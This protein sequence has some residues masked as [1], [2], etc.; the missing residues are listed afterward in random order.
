MVPYDPAP[1]SLT[2]NPPAF[3]PPPLYANYVGGHYHDYDFSFT[4]PSPAHYTDY[5]PTPPLEL[6]DPILASANRAASPFPYPR[7]HPS[8]LSQPH[9]PSPHTSTSFSQHYHPHSHSRSPHPSV[10]PQYAYHPLSRPTSA[11]STPSRDSSPPPLIHQFSPLGLPSEQKEQLPPRK[12]SAGDLL[13]WHHLARH[14]EIPGVEDDERARG[15]NN[16][17]AVIA[18]GKVSLSFDR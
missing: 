16:P 11:G 2:P 5:L 4:Q 6:A 18:D 8:A 3:I 10:P 15:E 1:S 17:P 9:H 14:G 13:H 12:L 7:G